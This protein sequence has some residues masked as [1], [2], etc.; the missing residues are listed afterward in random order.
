[1]NYYLLD[2][3]N[4]N[5]QH[6]YP[7]RKTCQHGYRKPHL[8]VLHTAENL[9]DYN[10]PD[11]GA[12]GVAKYA[13][14]TTR[15]VSWH[16][17]V[18]SDSKIPMLPYNYTGFHVRHFNRCSIGIEMAMQHDQWVNAPLEWLHG[19]YDNVADVLAHAR[20]ITGIPLINRVGTPE[21]WGY[22]T[23]SSLDPT[24]RRDPGAAFPID[25]VAE[26]AKTGFR[27]GAQPVVPEVPLE[28]VPL[29]GAPTVDI[30]TMQDWAKDERGTDLFVQLAVPCYKWSLVYGVDPAVPYAIMR[31][32]TNAGKFTDVLTVN[33]RNWG[34]IKTATGGGNRDPKAHQVFANHAQGVKAVVEHV[35]AYAGIEPYLPAD[36]RAHL[37]KGKRIESIPSD[38]WEWAGAGHDE[39]VV[40]Y[41]HEMR[42]A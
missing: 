32:E 28:S 8:I 7:Q 38:Q 36:P 42:K 37:L 25:W 10:P 9:P 41:V 20:A 2:N 27:Y 29:L 40:K 26:M 14:T 19:L 13:A 39:K 15:A 34:G 30:L 12:E 23:H 24:R 31:H 11:M 6:F 18:D 5:G 4:P 33:H 3:P 1:M 17:T 21:K 22:T 16:W 35:A